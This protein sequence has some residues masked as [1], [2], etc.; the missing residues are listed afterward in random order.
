MVV[1]HKSCG[2]IAFRE[3]NGFKEFLLLHYPSGHWDLPKGHVEDHDRDE[4]ATAV[5]ELEEETGLKP[6][7]VYDG[8]MTQIHYEYKFDGQDHEKDV[9]FFLIKVNDNEVNLSHEHKGFVWLDFEK[10][11]HKLTFDNAKDVLVAAQ[12]FLK[13]LS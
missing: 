13:C 12:G 6:K 9:D 4:I 7:Q 8:F 1:Y 11:L 5:R 10:A 3:S 2:C